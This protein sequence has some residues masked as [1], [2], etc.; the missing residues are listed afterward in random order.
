M[1]ETRSRSSM[2]NQSTDTSRPLSL[3]MGDQTTPAV[4]LRDWEGLR[5]A[6]EPEDERYWREPVVVPS[7]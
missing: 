5:F 4:Q 6:F 1:L 7:A 2:L 3:P